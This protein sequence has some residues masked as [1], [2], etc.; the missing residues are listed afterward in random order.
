M[1]INLSKKDDSFYGND[2]DIYEMER[3]GNV[4]LLN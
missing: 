2:E 1:I 3:L 4:M